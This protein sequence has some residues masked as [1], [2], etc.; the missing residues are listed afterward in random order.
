LLQLPISKRWTLALQRGATPTNGW[1]RS[2]KKL[3]MRAGLECTINLLGAC[4]LN[5]LTNPGLIASFSSFY[6]SGR[7]E[8]NIRAFHCD[9]C[10]SWHNVKGYHLKT[11]TPRT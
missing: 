2:A 11:Y 4:S 7:Y 3:Q 6:W 8:A 9:S 1:K 5:E 10:M